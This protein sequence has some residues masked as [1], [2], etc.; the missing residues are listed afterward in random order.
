MMMVCAGFQLLE[1]QYGCLLCGCNFI[2]EQLGIYFCYGRSIRFLPGRVF[3]K[4]V[5]HGV[6]SRPTN[7]ARWAT[8]STAV[9]LQEQSYILLFDARGIH[10]Q[11]VCVSVP[12]AACYDAVP[13][14]SARSDT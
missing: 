3:Q 10:Y 4:Y 2:F 5:A 1:S 6:P 11:S 12:K 7:P 13:C 9:S 8:R 14:C